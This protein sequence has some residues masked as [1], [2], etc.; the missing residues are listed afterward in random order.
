MVWVN[1]KSGVFHH[2][3][4][5][6]YSKTNEVKFMTEGD[7]LKAGDRAAK[8]GAAKKEGQRQRRIATCSRTTTENTSA[9]RS[10][11]RA[12]T[13]SEGAILCRHHAQAAPTRSAGSR[14]G[15]LLAVIHETSL[16]MRAPARSVCIQSDRCPCPYLAHIASAHG[17]ILLASRYCPAYRR[18][19]Q[20]RARIEAK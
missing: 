14:A 6:W 7:A 5:R 18:A 19:R 1:T 20:Y 2:E 11:A 15:A 8:E 16:L 12:T 10:L 17:L 3:G 9:T 13:G 4:D